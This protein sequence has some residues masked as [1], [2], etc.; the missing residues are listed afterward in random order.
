[1]NFGRCR[2]ADLE[3]NLDEPMMFKI[4]GFDQGY[5]SCGRRLNLAGVVI[6]R[7]VIHYLWLII[8]N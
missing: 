2:D 8:P 4:A 7:L 6:S 1:M 5:E 3:D